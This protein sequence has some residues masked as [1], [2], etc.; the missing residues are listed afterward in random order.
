M[1]KLIITTIVSLA[2]SSQIFAQNLTNASYSNP[3][4]RPASVDA[5]V[6]GTSLAAVRG[7]ERDTFEKVNDKRVSSG[8]T[9]LKWSEKAA[10]VAR[11][12]SVNMAEKDF[13]SHRGADG[14]MVDQR[15]DKARLFNWTAIGENIAFMQGY[16]KPGEMA[17]EQWL[18]SASHRNNLLNPRWTQTAIGIAV[19][20]D[21]KYYFTQVFLTEK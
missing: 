1:Q 10:E 9:S 18:L 15:A 5:S 2:F 21:G 19:T 17:I 3:A 14:L 12:H 16:P 20:K 11:L 13:F 7:L 6:G 4:S 8:L